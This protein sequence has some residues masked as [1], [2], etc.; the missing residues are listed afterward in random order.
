LRVQ[1][2]GQEGI[3]QGVESRVDAAVGLEEK[4]GSPQMIGESV[5]PR[6]GIEGEQGENASDGQGHDH[7]PPGGP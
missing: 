3:P 7:E 5:G 6:L 1:P 2:L 4:L